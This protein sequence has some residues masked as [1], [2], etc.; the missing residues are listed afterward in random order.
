MSTS[1]VS[2]ITT[3]TLCIIASICLMGL[4][5]AMSWETFTFISLSFAVYAVAFAVFGLIAV[6]AGKRD[7]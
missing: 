7:N 5:V 2:A 3:A 4:S 6:L 1:K